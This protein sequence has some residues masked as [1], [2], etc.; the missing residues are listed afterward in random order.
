[1]TEGDGFQVAEVEPVF[2][3]ILLL[4]FD[5]LAE[6]ALVEFA[7]EESSAHGPVEVIEAHH[8]LLAGSANGNGEA[9]LPEHRIVRYALAE[10]RVLDRIIAEIESLGLLTEEQDDDF[11]CLA[12]AVENAVKA[13]RP[14]ERRD[15]DTVREAA[16]LALR[17]T[18]KKLF[19]K[20]P[21]TRVQIVRLE[22]LAE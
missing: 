3:T 8:V 1:M 9:D 15:D 16:R 4:R 6:D 7:Q 12:E 21:M 19:G 22:E 14:R 13:L 18:A 17:R 20:K 10:C 5:Y 2:Y 11:D